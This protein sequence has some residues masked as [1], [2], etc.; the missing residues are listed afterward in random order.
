[1]LAPMLAAIALLAQ[2]HGDSVDLAKAADR[3]L[4]AR[5]EGFAGASVVVVRG[6]SIVL[7]KGYGSAGRSGHVDPDRTLFRAASVGKL[8]VATAAMQLA[9]AGSS[10][11]RETSQTTSPN[12]VL[13]LE[14]GRE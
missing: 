14:V 1:M 10:T 6:D 12:S 7:A 9:Q 4:G 13:K 8:F 3:V 5:T 2:A 11:S